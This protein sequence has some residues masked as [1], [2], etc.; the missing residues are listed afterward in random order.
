[1]EFLEDRES[2]TVAAWLRTQPQIHT[3][4]RDRSM[5]YAQG[6]SEGAP[7]AVQVADRWHLLK[8]LSETVERVL[9]DLLPRMKRQIVSA[10]DGLKRI[11]KGKPPVVFDVWVNTRWCSIYASRAMRKDESQGCLA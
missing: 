4:A 9:Q 3:V 5:Q 6:I 2:D 1:M 7:H 10:Y 11:W 8:N